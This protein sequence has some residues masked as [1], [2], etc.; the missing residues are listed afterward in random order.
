M[1]S[2]PSCITNCAGLRGST[3]PGSEPITHCRPRRWFTRLIC[4]CFESEPDKLS[5]AI[6]RKEEAGDEEQ[7][8]VTLT[9]ELV[10]GLRGDSPE[11]LR[12]RL[13]GD[14][15]NIMMKAIRKEPPERYN[16]VEQFSQDLR[17]EITCG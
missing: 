10:S 16:S 7:E 6:Q 1:R 8:Q 14:L 11:N 2:S 9:P 5:T 4:A 12:R 17:R 3:S 13:A 15:D